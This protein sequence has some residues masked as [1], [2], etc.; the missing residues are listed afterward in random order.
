MRAVRLFIALFLIVIAPAAQAQLG[1]RDGDAQRGGQLALRV[2]EPCHTVGS[3]PSSVPSAMTGYG[4]SF[5]AIANSP[6]ATAQSLR[7]FL[8]SPHAL[9]RMTHPNLT[10][11]QRADVIAYILSLRDRR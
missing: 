7:T 9:S 6:N 3:Q 1:Q 11:E 2:C 10:E 5:L 8:S 4:P